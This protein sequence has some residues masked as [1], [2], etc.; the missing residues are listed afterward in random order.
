MAGFIL[1]LIIRENRRYMETGALPAGWQAFLQHAFIPLYVLLLIWYACTV[2][3]GW[4]VH[5]RRSVSFPVEPAGW[6]VINL[7]AFIGIA[8]YASIQ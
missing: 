8:I 4:T 5:R 6:A 7:L 2:F 1:M 3:K